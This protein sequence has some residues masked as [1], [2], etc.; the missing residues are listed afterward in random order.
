MI[1]LVS[2]PLAQDKEDNLLDILRK[3]KNSFP[4]FPSVVISV[5]QQ[6]C[7]M[8]TVPYNKRSL[9]FLG[10]MKKY[11]FASFYKWRVSRLIEW[12]RKTQKFFMSREEKF[13]YMF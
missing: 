1:L 12:Q 2:V 8:K 9:M 4:L 7:S 11:K 13:L 5:I 3:K 10:F 6:Q